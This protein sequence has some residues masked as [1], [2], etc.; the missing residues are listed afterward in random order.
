MVAVAPRHIAS[1]RR[2]HVEEAPG[3]DHVVIDAGK[4][5]YT[6]HAPT[7]AY[8]A[9]L[10]IALFVY[11]YYYIFYTITYRIRVMWFRYR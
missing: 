9:R 10:H 7:D 1:K 3:N 8:T 11:Y 5:R 6:E 4:H 2:E